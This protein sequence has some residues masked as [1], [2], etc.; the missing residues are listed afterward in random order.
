MADDSGI[1]YRL[2]YWPVLQ[3]R[4]EYVRL[5]LEEAGAEYVDVA[6]L[7]EAEGGGI[8]CI[9]D[10]RAGKGEDDCIFAPPA[11]EHGDLLLFQ[12]ANI[13]MYLGARHGLTPQGDQRFVA[14]QLQ[15]TISDVAAE[16][17]NTHH[18]VSVALY[19]EDQREAAIENTR[20]FLGDRLPKFLDF[21]ERVLTHNGGE[22]LV[23][24]SISYVDLSMFQTLAGLEYAFPRG[25]AR[26]IS[27]APALA[28]LKEAVAMRPRIAAYLQ[29]PRRLPWNE[30]GI[31]RHY[32]ELD[33][34]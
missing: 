23:G 18:P 3:G 4:G 11:L 10:L 21:F 17:H 13:C 31:F 27:K 28:S 24:E 2:Y 14:N 33:L 8:Q 1:P 26:A 34:A 15:L 20:V 6:R 32:P 7:P 30:H 5:V 12:T 9:L 16:V 22:V 25:Y 19:Y 29:S